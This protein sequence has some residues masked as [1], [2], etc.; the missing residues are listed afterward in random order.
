MKTV[1]ERLKMCLIHPAVRNLDMDSPGSNRILSRVIQQKIFLRRIYQLW[2]LDLA[3]SLPENVTGSVLELGSGA[4]FLKKYIPDL[5]SS[6]ILEVPNVDIVLDGHYL[7]FADASLRAIV[8]L[9]VFHHLPRVKFFLKEAARCIKPGGVIVMIEPWCTKWSRFVYAHLHH[10][11]FFPEA[12]S[13]HFPAGGPLSSANSALP[14]IVFKRDRVIF[15][16]EF[17]YWQ[18]LEIEVHTPFAYLL[19]GGL[20]MRSFVPGN[21]FGLCR[22]I[23]SRLA[24]WMDSLAMFATI[25]LKREE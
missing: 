22:K 2:Y 13:W 23:E 25:V 6:E 15:Q 21:G 10:E 7:P 24:P 3:A 9:D 17:P 16:N 14:W 4:G 20:S 18:V 8:M 12:K 5:I 1:S 19:S 11:P